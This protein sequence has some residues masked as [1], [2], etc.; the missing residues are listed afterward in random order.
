MSNTILQQLDDTGLF[1]DFDNTAKRHLAAC[2]RTQS[3]GDGE[4][5]YRIGDE[6]TVLYG[7]LEAT[8]KLLGENCSGK[9]CLF[10]IATPGCWLRLISI[11]RRDVCPG[12][13]VASYR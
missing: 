3:F 1:R 11:A 9:C 5:I 4:L 13:I 10:G 6:A 8:V 12:G 2:S 7:V